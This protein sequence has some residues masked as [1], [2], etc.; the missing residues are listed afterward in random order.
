MYVVMFPFSPQGMYMALCPRAKS[1]FCTSGTWNFEQKMNNTKIKYM[2][3]RRT[4]YLSRVWKGETFQQLAVFEGGI[5][6]A[7]PIGLVG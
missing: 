5:I 6:L 2:P 3:W 1:I 4:T 7:S